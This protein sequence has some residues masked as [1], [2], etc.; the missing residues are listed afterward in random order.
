MLLPSFT[1]ARVVQNPA[2]DHS[3]TGSSEVPILSQINFKISS[4]SGS[5]LQASD[6]S[7]IVQNSLSSTL[8]GLIT[9]KFFNL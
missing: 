8:S 2:N 6:K 1:W 7:L 3:L 4:K 9:L 5:L